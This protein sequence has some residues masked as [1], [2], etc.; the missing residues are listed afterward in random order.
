MI[1][2]LLLTALLAQAAPASPPCRVGAFED[3]AF[4][5]GKWRVTVNARLSARGPWEKTDATSTI[6]ADLMGC[7]FIEHLDTTRE[8]HPLQLLSI[9]TYDH[10]GGRWQYTVTDSE[11]GRMQ[12]YEG[13][14][15]AD[16]F[17][18][19]VNLDVPGGKVLL[20]R[21]LK[22]ESDDAFTWE[23]ARSPDEGKTWDV[24]TRFEYRR[25]EPVQR[26]E[27]SSISRTSLMAATFRSIGNRS[28]DADFRNPDYMASRFLRS[29]DLELLASP[30]APTIV[31]SLHCRALSSPSTSATRL[32]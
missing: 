27:A 26:V 9:L 14:R 21:T 3:V 4:Y 15:D 31:P 8:G 19:L 20:R 25:V 17:V 24:T 10:N 23:S 18:L 11:H 2:T 7:A 30:A 28:P 16:A 13:R 32:P 12:T 1:T 6:V 22:K 5:R 29:A